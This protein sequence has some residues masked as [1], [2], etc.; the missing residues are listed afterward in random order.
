M[1]RPKKKGIYAH[2]LETLARVKFAN[3][4]INEN[5]KNFKKFLDTVSN[6]VSELVNLRWKEK[7]RWT[8]GRT[9]WDDILEMVENREFEGEE[10]R[11]DEE[12]TTVSMSKKQYGSYK[13]ALM[14]AN[15]SY[16]SPSVN[17]HVNGN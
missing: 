2:R 5:K 14:A 8:E 17:G 11:A 13:E 12:W 10:S 3:E 1:R 15:I 7:L 16:G 6:Y 9:I 4:G